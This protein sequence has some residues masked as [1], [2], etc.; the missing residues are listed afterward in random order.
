MLGH[1]GDQVGVGPFGLAEAEII[2][3]C[4][5]PAQELARPYPHLLERR[6]D[7][8]RAGRVLKILD[9]EGLKAPGADCGQHL[10]AKSRTSDC[11]RW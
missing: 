11:A 2:I 1:R 4:A 3:G 7:F 5:A 10:S 6:A 8:G 9:D